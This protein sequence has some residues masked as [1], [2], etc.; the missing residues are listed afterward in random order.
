ML[1]GHLQV[2]LSVSEENGKFV[3]YTYFHNF[4][5]KPTDIIPAAF[6]IEITNPQ[7]RRLAALSPEKAMARRSVAEVIA[8]AVAGGAQGWSDASGSQRRTGSAT[9]YNPDGSTSQVDIYTTGPTPQEIDQR[10]RQAENRRSEAAE[11]DRY[12]QQIRNTALLANT[13]DPQKELTG[14][15]WFPREKKN[16]HELVIDMPIGGTVFEFPFYFK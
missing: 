15:V 1:P 10:N 16:Y 4:D 12:N 5:T 6:S 14:A 2:A 13:L 9:V 8:T 7:G 3:A 11:R